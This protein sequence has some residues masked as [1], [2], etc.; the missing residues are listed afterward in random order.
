MRPA[1]GPAEGDGPASAGGAKRAVRARALAARDALP[2]DARAALSERVCTRALA[3]PEL[4]GATTVMLF[5]S[6]RTEVDT[7]PLIRACLA[8]GAVV[9][10]PRIAGP[11]LLEAVRVADPVRDLEPGTWGIPE[12]RAGLPVADPGIIDLA[13]V[14]GAAFSAAGGRCGYGGGFYDAFLPRLR[15]GTPLVGLAFETQVLDDV[16]CEPHDLAVDVVVTEAR[17]IRCRIA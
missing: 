17:V 5:A 7:G 9:A 11:R 15:R 1:P 6:F 3:L 16:P 13:F 10:L 14:P 2:P 12:P 8:R 4:A